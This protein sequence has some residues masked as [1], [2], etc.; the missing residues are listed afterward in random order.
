MLVILPGM[1]IEVLEG[2]PSND[3]RWQKQIFPEWPNRSKFP[4]RDSIDPSQ[5]LWAV[6][7]DSAQMFSAVPFSCAIRYERIVLLPPTNQHRKS[8]L[9]RKHRIRSAFVLLHMIYCQFGPNAKA[10]LLRLQWT[11]LLVLLDLKTKSSSNC[12]SIYLGHVREEYSLVY[13]NPMLEGS[14]L[15]TVAYLLV[16]GIEFLVFWRVVCCCSHVIWSLTIL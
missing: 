9:V 16:A 13:Y 6:A 4:V 12:C 8:I 5:L 10:W 14:W 2:P 3:L 11:L 15:L 1:G 7:P